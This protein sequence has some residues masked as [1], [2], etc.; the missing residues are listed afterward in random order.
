VKC[1][2][3]FLAKNA[4]FGIG[5]KWCNTKPGNMGKLNLGWNVSLMDS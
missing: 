4:G 5:E 1:T 2:D 3:T